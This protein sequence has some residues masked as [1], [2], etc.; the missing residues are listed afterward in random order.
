[1]EK[2]RIITNTIYENLSK[3]VDIALPKII[4][5]DLSWKFQISFAFLHLLKIYDNYSLIKLRIFPSGSL[6]HAT[7]I[8]PAKCISS[9]N[10]VLGIS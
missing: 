6:N 4:D 5:K 3:K 10:V 9:F 2:F 7:F 8:S 1:M